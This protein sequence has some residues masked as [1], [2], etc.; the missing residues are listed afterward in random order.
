MRESIECSSSSFDVP[1][2]SISFGA[3]FFANS[4]EASL[5]IRQR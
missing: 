1:N 5:N 4:R 3:T 2:V